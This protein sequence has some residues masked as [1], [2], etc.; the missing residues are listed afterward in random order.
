MRTERTGV[1]GRE[2][3]R[4]VGGDRQPSRPHWAGKGLDEMHATAG[5]VPKDKRPTNAEDS[6]KVPGGGRGGLGSRGVT[7]E[8]VQ[9]GLGINSLCLDFRKRTEF[10][11]D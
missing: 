11:G 1:P 7:T 3:T 4:T 2:R 6:H 5:P 9:P 8:G 10:R